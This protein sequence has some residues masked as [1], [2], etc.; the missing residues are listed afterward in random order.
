MITLDTNADDLES[1][2]TVRHLPSGLMAIHHA[3]RDIVYAGLRNSNIHCEDLRVRGGK[4]VPM[5]RLERGKAVVAVKRLKD[6]AV[7]YGLVASGMLSEVS[8]ITTCRSA[9]SHVQQPAENVVF[10]CCCSTYVMVPNL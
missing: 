8:P 4:T 3:D 2:R 1:S 9:F 5:A 7:P 6:S 10:S